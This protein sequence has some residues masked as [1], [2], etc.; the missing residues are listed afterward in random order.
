M[1]SEDRLKFL[2]DKRALT[3]KEMEEFKKLT[4]K[5][6]W[7]LIGNWK[8]IGSIDDFKKVSKNFRTIGEKIQYAINSS[9]YI[10]AISLRLMLIDIALRLFLNNNGVNLKT[11]KPSELQ[12]GSLLKEIERY[13]FDKRLRKKLINF[14]RERIEA[15]HNFI[16]NGVDYNSF[17]S[18]IIKTNNLATDVWN[19]CTK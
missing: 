15:I 14:N 9:C 13:N 11:K 5:G 10:E 1:D 18:F 19:Y 16:Y 8:D 3:G 6:S 12:F 17:Y 4:P 2:R 7:E